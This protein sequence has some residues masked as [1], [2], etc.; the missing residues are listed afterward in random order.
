M[1]YNFHTSNISRCLKSNFPKKPI[2]GGNELVLCNQLWI[3]LHIKLDILE[4]KSWFKCDFKKTLD[5]LWRNTV[6][7]YF[8]NN[9]TLVGKVIQEKRRGLF[10]DIFCTKKREGKR[11]NTQS[12]LPYL[13]ILPSGFLYISFTFST[14]L[15]NMRW[16]RVSL[17]IHFQRQWPTFAHNMQKS[18][19]W[20]KISD[21]IF[22]CLELIVPF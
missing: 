10:L 17:V 4:D 8:V 3:P 1:H 9:V 12:F 14:P 18:F 19:I 13:F 6:T 20:R 16:K 15:K 7:V 5:L 21:W 2:F 22:F 11:V